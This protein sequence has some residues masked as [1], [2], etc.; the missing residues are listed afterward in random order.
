MLSYT[1]MISCIDL[2]IEKSANTKLIFHWCL[3]MLLCLS[4]T[5]FLE[6]DRWYHPFFKLP[7]WYLPVT[8]TVFTTH[9]WDC[10]V[11]ADFVF[12]FLSLNQVVSR[13][14]TCTP[15]HLLI[16]AW[17]EGYSNLSVCLLPDILR[18]YCVLCMKQYGNGRNTYYSVKNMCGLLQ[19]HFV[20]ERKAV[21]RRFRSVFGQSPYWNYL[22]HGYL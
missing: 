6:K 17:A 5:C 2:M 15:V 8:L 9:G 18:K 7:F 4:N 16:R 10:A 20:S 21:R 14:G 22:S 19:N 1:L 11:F 13:Q 3:S 12:L